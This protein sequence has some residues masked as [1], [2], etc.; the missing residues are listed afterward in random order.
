MTKRSLA[1]FRADSWLWALL[2]AGSA[3]AGA[4]CAPVCRWAEGACIDLRIEGAGS[5]SSYS[6]EWRY[7]I[8][9]EPQA[10]LRRGATESG[11][12]L[13]RTFRVLPPPGVT[14]ES[15]RSMGVLGLSEDGSEQAGGSIELSLSEG[16]QPSKV[17]PLGLRVSRHNIAL[18]ASSA[19]VIAGDFNKDTAID[20]AVVGTPSGAMASATS[21][22]ILSVLYGVGDGTYQPAKTFDIPTHASSIVAADVDGDARLDLLTTGAGDSFSLFPNSVTGQFGSRTSIL[23]TTGALSGECQSGSDPHSLAVADFNGDGFVDIAATLRLRPCVSLLLGTS[24]TS[25]VPK[26]LAPRPTP[27][28]AGDSLTKLAVADFNQ[29]G[30]SDVAVIRTTE[31]L[32]NI[33][34]LLSGDKESGFTVSSIFT[35]GNEPTGIIA[36]DFNGDHRS[37]VAILGS[38]SLAQSVRLREGT[39]QVGT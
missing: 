11:G 22:G 18:G 16:E 29:D 17:L 24:K 32:G 3:L 27:V 1:S 31:G 38:G 15:V 13:P 21:G 20:L 8:P 4:S 36:D 10:A 28:V 23:S 7:G 37:A 14:A 6:I 33:A 12:E 5:Y 2:L 19:H 26:D 30:F 9:V 35:A 39:G 34:V 25:F